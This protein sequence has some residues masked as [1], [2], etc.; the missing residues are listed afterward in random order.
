MRLIEVGVPGLSHL[1][2]GIMPTD[3]KC[4]ECGKPLPKD[5]PKGLCP[6]CLLGVVVDPPAANAGEPVTSEDASSEVD[7]G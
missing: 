5:A 3:H 7:A 4:P 1:P 2:H 6:E